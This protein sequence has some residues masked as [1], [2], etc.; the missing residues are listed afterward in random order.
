MYIGL[1]TIAL[2]F[3]AFKHK[4]GYTGLLKI[5]SFQRRTP[6]NIDKLKPYIAYIISNTAKPVKKKTKIVFQD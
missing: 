2:N 4:E 1:T 5:I 3:I 6:T